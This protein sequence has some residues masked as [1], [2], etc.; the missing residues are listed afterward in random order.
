M[1]LP[2]EQPV[3]GHFIGRDFQCIALASEEQKRAKE[4]SRIRT[5]EVNDQQQQLNSAQCS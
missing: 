5:S 2:T 4:L 3:P 1:K